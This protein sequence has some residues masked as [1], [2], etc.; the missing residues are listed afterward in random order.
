MGGCEMLKPELCELEITPEIREK[1]QGKV[2]RALFDNVDRFPPRRRTKSAVF[3]LTVTQAKER[4]EMALPAYRHYL[5]E[6]LPVSW[7]EY[8]GDQVEVGSL[9][10]EWI[11]EAITFFRQEGAE[12]FSV[13]ITHPAEEAYRAVWSALF[14]H[15]LLSLVQSSGMLRDDSGIRVCDLVV[16]CMK[17]WTRRV[18]DYFR[19]AGLPTSSQS[20]VFLDPD[21]DLEV[22]LRFDGR[23]IHLRGR[24]DAVLFDRARGEIHVWEY[25]FGR[26]GQ[27]ELQI[28]QLLLYM[29]LLDH[30]AGSEPR[31]GFLTIFRPVVDKDVPEEARKRLQLDDVEPPFPDAIEKTFAGYVGQRAAV[32][33]LKVKLTVA[34]RRNP[35]RMA[36]NI[37]MCGPGGLGK[38][39]LARRVARALGTPLVDKPSTSFRNLEDLISKIDEALAAAGL[40]PQAV[41]TDSGL[42]KFKYPPLVLFVDEAHA[43]AKR[44]DEYLN[45]FEPTER[46][47]VT[48]DR[49]ADFSDATILLATT[50]KGKL[51]GPFLSRFGIVDLVPYS[52]DEVGQI[53]KEVFQREGTEVS[54]EVCHML[55]RIGRL[56]P[57]QAMSKAGEFLEHHS[58]SQSYYPLTLEGLKKM[59]ER[60]WLVDQN[61]L[62]P[63]DFAYLRAV[64][65]GPKGIGPLCSL[66]QCGQHEIL[67][68]IEPYLLQIRAI[69]LTNRGREITELGRAILATA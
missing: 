21:L 66:V 14:Q 5:G 40:Q 13:A 46:R 22:V 8:A 57:R 55:A 9:L 2:L 69:K 10:H 61:G 68:V 43:L 38:T 17:L 34:L 33:T 4:L 48:R 60:H 49:V 65:T 18:C 28:V 64:E 3:S 50:D 15:R 12:L 41:G 30:S 26:Q 31:R 63:S 39:E 58:C 44:S 25:K 1:I 37:M 16:E 51:P 59:M 7:K 27:Y 20:V 54:D 67:T 36:A 23:A 6:L 56:I 19:R 47:A 32:H 53:V 52:V 42:P 29:V 24:P 45:F 62:V 11:K 35:P